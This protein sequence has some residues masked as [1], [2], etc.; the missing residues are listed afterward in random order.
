MQKVIT[1]GLMLGFIA[2][3]SNISIA[4]KANTVTCTGP[5]I[6][7]SLRPKASMAVIYDLEGGHAC[8]VERKASAQDPVRPC[9]PGHNCHLEGTYSRKNDTTYV[10]DKVS[11]VDVVEE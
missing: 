8:V 5:L 9:S 2:I 3:A 10:I 6:D 4:Q 7:L 1:I 11:S